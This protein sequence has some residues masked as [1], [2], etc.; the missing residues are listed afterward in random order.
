MSPIHWD[1]EPSSARVD[2]GA[3]PLLRAPQ[4]GSVTVWLLAPFRRLRTHWVKNK[5][6]L[7]CERPECPHCKARWRVRI[8]IFA[9]A[10]YYGVPEGAHTEQ[11]YEVV[12]EATEKCDDLVGKLDL[13]GKYLKLHRCGKK[14]NG[15]VRWE[16]LPA[17]KQPKEPPPV[18]A[19]DMTDTLEKIYDSPDRY[20][21][22]PAEPEERD[23]EVAKHLLR[24]PGPEERPKPKEPAKPVTAEDIAAG[25]KIL[26]ENFARIGLT[27]RGAS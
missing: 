5:Y 6:T 12:V 1:D 22:P 19:F 8:K 23:P 7:P 11:W 20:E 18:P 3:R 2:Q 13:V 14:A 25:K 24:M 16:L 21:L 10:L 15:K 4:A 17:A 27:P 9:P 26:R